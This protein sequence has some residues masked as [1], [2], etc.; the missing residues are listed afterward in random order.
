MTPLLDRFP[1]YTNA[2][3]DGSFPLLFCDLELFERNIDRI[4][5]KARSAG[6]TIRIHTK[7]IRSPEL[8]RHILDH[9]GPEFRGLMTFSPRETNYLAKLG[10]DDFI[11]A[12]PVASKEEAS[13]LARMASD[14]YRI[15]TVVDSPYH[16]DLLERAARE[17]RCTLET[18]I[19]MDCSWEPFGFLHLGLRRSPVRKPKDAENLISSLRSARHVRAVA[20]MGYEG[21]IAGPADS[22]PGRFLSNA[23]LG[24]LKN[25]SMKEYMP[26]RGELVAYLRKA[27][28]PVE[29]INGGGSGSLEYTLG[30][31]SITEATVGSAFYAPSL[32]WHYRTEDYIPSLFFAL[33]VCRIPGPGFVCCSG[34][35]YIASGPSGSS[36]L[37]VPVFPRGLGYIDLEGA[38]EVQTPLRLPKGLGMAIGDPVYFQHAKAGEPCERF[39]EIRLIRNGN[40]VGSARTYRTYIESFI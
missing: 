13:I 33:R 6:K 29:T 23:I 40:V 19:E 26:R 31:P 36:R 3:K 4:R 1:E 15:R 39:S 30:D 32:F 34:G 9:G 16:V 35:G 11:L 2:L 27:G 14:G 17:H 37:P 8:I 12:Y 10:F 7:S 24:L 25:A 18:C 38:G 5:T 22:V 20:L 28:L 21:H